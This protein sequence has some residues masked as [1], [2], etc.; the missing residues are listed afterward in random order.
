MVFH[1]LEPQIASTICTLAQLADLNKHQ[2]SIISV[3]QNLGV[4]KE[5][6]LMILSEC[7]ELDKIE[8]DNKKQKLEFIQNCF[9]HF[10]S[11]SKVEKSEL[12]LYQH[13]TKTL[14]V[15]VTSMN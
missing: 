2:N 3:A 14:G 1:D 13:V 5:D 11:L 8:L 10:T 7:D 15:S 4:P 12:S 6:T 9:S